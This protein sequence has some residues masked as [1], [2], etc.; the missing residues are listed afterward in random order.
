MW[1]KR[2]WSILLV[3]KQRDLWKYFFLLSGSSQCSHSRIPILTAAE[4]DRRDTWISELC[5]HLALKQNA[6]LTSEIYVPQFV[7]PY[8]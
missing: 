1:D 7:N 2:S 3:K 4:I 8:L 6:C 5:L